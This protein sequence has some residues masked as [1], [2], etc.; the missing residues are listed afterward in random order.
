[1]G[2]VQRRRCLP[3]APPGGRIEEARR[4]VC[5]SALPS[6]QGARTS[7]GS[8]AQGGGSPAAQRLFERGCTDRSA[9]RCADRRTAVTARARA[10]AACRT[11]TIRRR[12]ASR[13][14]GSSVPLPEHTVAAVTPQAPV[15]V[16]RRCPQGLGKTGHRDGRTAAVQRTSPSCLL[17]KQ[18]EET[19]EGES[20]HALGTGAAT[21]CARAAPRVRRRQ[22]KTR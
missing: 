6:R 21:S 2:R 13:R 20:S 9:D 14:R 12:P 7:P 10:S 19:G 3:C 11:R 5:S 15:H 16:S 4:S 8:P 22:E 17:G 1:M 18:R